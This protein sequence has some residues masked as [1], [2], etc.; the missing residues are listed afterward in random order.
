MSL[1]KMNMYKSIGYLLISIFMLSCVTY[2][3]FTI[4]DTNNAHLT[5]KTSG[6]EAE[7]Q[8]YVY[9]NKYHYGSNHQTLIDNTCVIG[10]VE[11]LCYQEIK[12]PIYPELIE[13]S[14]APGERFSFAIAIQSLG[15]M[16]GYVELKLGNLESIGYD[17]AENKIQTAFGYEVTKISYIYDDIETEDLKEDFNYQSY[18]LFDID[19]VKSYHLIQD[20]PLVHEN[21][22]QG[23]LVVYFDLYYDPTVFGID[24]ND[25]PYTNSHIFMQQS[26]HVHDV[27]M[28]VSTQRQGS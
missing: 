4:T 11:D 2:A 10:S 19:D 26:L 7:Y 25:M 20:V 5:T 14:V 15:S 18:R 27:Y 8:F 9:K 17:R 3:W 1:T 6:V 16:Q 22:F 13:G 24:E 28:H 12:N 21:Q 23:T